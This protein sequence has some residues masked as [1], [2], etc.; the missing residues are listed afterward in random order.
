MEKKKII[1][2]ISIIIIILVLLGIILYKYDNSS[3]GKE[4]TIESNS[5]E[6]KEELNIESVDYSALIPVKG[7]IKK[8]YT[9]V[10]ANTK[11]DQ[12]NFDLIDIYIMDNNELIVTQSYGNDVIS[13]FGSY[14]GSFDNDNI[15]IV[16]K[17]I[18]KGVGCSLYSYEHDIIDIYQNT[19][20]SVF[21]EELDASKEVIKLVDDGNNS[22]DLLKTFECYRDVTN[23]Q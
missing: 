14:A 12:V 23:V 21:F 3:K 22:K 15:K 19:D 16:F 1:I 7:N 5:T 10:A 2:L 13:Y 11:T 8:H 9:G 17:P 18:L 6:S 4:S 20:E